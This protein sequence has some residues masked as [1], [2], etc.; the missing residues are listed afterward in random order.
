MRNEERERRL[1]RGAKE[2]FDP[3]G[4]LPTQASSDGLCVR[5]SR[6]LLTLAPLRTA[7]FIFLPSEVSSSELRRA[8]IASGGSNKR[9]RVS[10][11]KCDRSG[12]GEPSSSVTSFRGEGRAG[13]GVG[14]GGFVTSLPFCGVTI[15]L[16]FRDRFG[17]FLSSSES[18]SDSVRSI[19]ALS[20]A[21]LTGEAAA[22]SEGE[23]LFF[24][25]CSLSSS[26][27]PDGPAST[28]GAGATAA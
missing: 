20:S 5:R 24:L 14:S 7:I 1:V 23:A 17:G 27:R 19:K 16:P 13:V 18:E 21:A 26:E 2:A 15:G 28:T 6:A 25:I 8:K 3:L 22:G 11:A 9:C 12:G 10:C 4:A